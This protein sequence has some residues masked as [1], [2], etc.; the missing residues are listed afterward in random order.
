MRDYL[1]IKALWHRKDGQREEKMPL[2][3]ELAQALQQRYDGY[4]TEERRVCLLG[5]KLD[6][7]DCGKMMLHEERRCSLQTVCTIFHR[8]YKA[9]YDNEP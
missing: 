6:E 5:L 9:D 1:W 2:Y 4:V 3:S 8:Q 7:G